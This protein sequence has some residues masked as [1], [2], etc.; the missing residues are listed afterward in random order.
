MNNLIIKPVDFNGDQL[1]AVKDESSGKIYTGV[2]YICRGL[3]LTEG[4]SKN[5]KRKIQEDLVLSKGGR[6]LVLPTSGGNQ[7]ALCIEVEFLPLWL[8]KI[9]ITPKMQEESPELTE[10]LVQYQLKAKDVLAQAFLSKEPKVDYNLEF[11]KEMNKAL[12]NIQDEKIRDS[13]CRQMFER[14][15]FNSPC[16]AIKRELED[17]DK[18]FE[19]VKKFIE[20][21]CIIDKGS[22]I[23]VS[24]LY[25][26]FL[27]WCKDVNINVSQVIFSKKLKK[28][29]VEQGRKTD[30]RFWRGL[31]RR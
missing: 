30:F 11:L 15:G 14:I 20:E 6:N 19:V 25:Q 28:L 24:D 13:V 10:K 1:M 8:A 27:E 4:Q 18:E 29:G 16:A 23:T 17:K 3:G 22:L 21:N 7:E 5:E 31:K 26:M 12:N 2:S 9:S